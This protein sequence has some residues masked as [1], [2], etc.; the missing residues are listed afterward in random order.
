MKNSTVT[1]ALLLSSFLAAPSLHAGTVAN[2]SSDPVAVRP[3]TSGRGHLVT[4]MERGEGGVIR[5]PLTI[6]LS[7]VTTDGRLAVLGAY[8]VAFD[9]DRTKVAFVGVARGEAPEFT[10]VPAC[11]P[12]T[13]ANELGLV[14]IVGDQGTENLPTGVISVAVVTFRELTPGGAAT[15]KPRIEGLASSLRKNREGHFPSDLTI[16]ADPAK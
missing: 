3:T 9:F 14:K 6:D 15:I 13:K 16:P 4:T 2:S 7:D 1:S 12:V 11:T 8:I 5:I 10:L